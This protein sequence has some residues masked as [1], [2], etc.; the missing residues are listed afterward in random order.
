M[1]QKM[2]EHL[3]IL[4]SY[5]AVLSFIGGFLGT[6]IGQ[7]VIDVFDWLRRR[8]GAQRNADGSPTACQEPAPENVA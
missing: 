5:S 3:Q 4:M 2:F 7:V 1:E 8:H 6:V